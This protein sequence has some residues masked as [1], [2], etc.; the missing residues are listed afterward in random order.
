MIKVLQRTLTLNDSPFD[1]WFLIL[2]IPF[3]GIMFWYV[4]PLVIAHYLIMTMGVLS[5]L[6]VFCIDYLNRNKTYIT[7]RSLPNSD[8]CLLDSFNVLI[9]LICLIQCV[10]MTIVLIFFPIQQY[11]NITLIHIS[12]TLLIATFCVKTLLEE[13]H[14]KGILYTITF[15]LLFIDI[16]YI[17]ILTNTEHFIV[18]DIISGVLFGVSCIAFSTKSVIRYR[19]LRHNQIKL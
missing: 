1:K 16:S 15:T 3:M 5:I 8:R 10:G 12:M 11:A 4:S 2:F 6:P 13:R 14:N 9:I 18:F 19:R 17:G 7:F